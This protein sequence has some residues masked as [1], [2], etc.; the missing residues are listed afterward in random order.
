MKT[1]QA[2][3]AYTNPQKVS[4]Y[5]MHRVAFCRAGFFVAER[6]DGGVSEFETRCAKKEPR[7]PSLSPKMRV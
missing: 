2:L 3:T 6:E 5:G 1:V 4:L 7:F